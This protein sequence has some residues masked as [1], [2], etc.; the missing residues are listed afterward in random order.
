MSAARALALLERADSTWQVEAQGEL[1][2]EAIRLAREAADPDVE[3]AARMRAMPNAA[4]RFA[5]GEAVT[6]LAWC[7]GR[8]ETDA[9]RYARR[10]PGTEDLLYLEDWGLRQIV[11]SDALPP[12]RVES[13]VAAHAAR[14]GDGAG[15]HALAV[16]RALQ[17]WAAGDV[18]AASTRID[19]A[20]QIPG[21]AMT[22]CT[23]CTRDI[24]AQI[25]EAGGQWEKVAAAVDDFVSDPCG[26]LDQP[27]SALSRGLFAWRKAGRI[28]DAEAAYAKASREVSGR[29]TTPEVLGRL[30][31]YAL[32]T[33]RPDEAL[34]HVES[35]LVWVKGPALATHLRLGALREVSAVLAG[36]E[37][38]GLGARR[39]RSADDPRA[40]LLLPPRDG[41]WTVAEAAPVLHEAARVLAA[42]F[43]DRAAT[44]FHVEQLARSREV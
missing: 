33:A 39:L 2:D 19:A 28:E 4:V 5:V 40:R 37:S 9:Q 29:E 11:L 38:S 12:D 30:A 23:R 20:L 41:G 35:A 36:L 13:L 22:H 14:L 31:R 26:D 21:D 17:A 18:P 44:T 3:Y 15:E 8:H 1:L 10:L 25:H 32:L 7:L 43:D 27:A 24:A 42:R 16:L 6:H 34:A